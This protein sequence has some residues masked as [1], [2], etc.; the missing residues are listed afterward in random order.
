MSA[1]GAGLPDENKGPEILGASV[2]VTT[3]A[4]IAVIIRLVVR[5]RMVRRVGTDDYAMV[6]AML[7]SLGGLVVI[8]GQVLYGA[9]RH[10]AYLDPQVNS[11]GLKYNFAGQ[12]IYM[13][14][15]PAVKM[16]VGFFLLRIAP[17]KTYRRI[18]QGVMVFT[19]AYTMVCFMTLLLQC[20]NLAVLWDPT[21]KT[22][23]WSMSTLQ[24]L[25]YT[26]CV[27][28]ILTDVFFAILPI[29]MLWNVQINARTRASLICILGL[30]IF[31]CAAGIVKAA[32]IS[33]YGKT[34]DFLWDSANLTIW[35]SVECNVGI[36]AG[37]LPCL[38]PLFKR[39]LV[40]SLGYGSSNKKDTGSGYKLRSHSHAS[41]P[42]G[43]KYIRSRSPLP[44]KVRNPVKASTMIG[45]NI[46]EESILSQS[47]PQG[48]TKTTVVTV[49]S[50]ETDARYHGGSGW[51]AT[52][53]FR[54]QRVD[55]S[56]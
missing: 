35:Y 41:T 25:S 42:K 38:K 20:Q 33:N 4:L 26:S 10:A 9:G 24:G 7:L 39:I 1:P 53:G 45:D 15:L 6:I 44:A 43:S 18:L 31:A 5:R 34:G 51:S 2:T 21:V 50:A 30:G 11:M 52:S 27:V 29:P 47:Q 3:I 40:S 23:C 56:M 36:L 8:I 48:I 46:S 37:C 54:E 13:W 17:N 22:T 28:N 19:V 55:D 49:D 16:S 32:F 14:A 12:A